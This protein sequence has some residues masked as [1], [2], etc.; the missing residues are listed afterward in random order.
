MRWLKFLI[1]LSGYAA[2]AFF[3]GLIF[4]S[5]G[6]PGLYLVMGITSIAI[7]ILHMLS[8]QLLPPPD[9]KMREKEEGKERGYRSILN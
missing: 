9:G 7:F 1:Y 5:L 3:G 2:A 8:L 6:G 4:S